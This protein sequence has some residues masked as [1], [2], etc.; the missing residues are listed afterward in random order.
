MANPAENI[1]YA[2]PGV[3]I[4]WRGLVLCIGRPEDFGDHENNLGYDIVADHSAATT[5]EVETII[6][7]ISRQ[8]GPEIEDL[9]RALERV[10]ASFPVSLPPHTIAETLIGYLHTGRLAG[11][12]IPPMMGAISSDSASEL[13]QMNDA[14]TKS[15]Q[16]ALLAPLDQITIEDLPDLEDRIVYALRRG[17]SDARFGDAVAQ[18]QEMLNP[19]VLAIIAAVL[20]LWVLSHATPIGY[21]IDAVMLAAGWIAIGWAIFGVIKKLFRAL[22]KILNA[23]T[24][25]ELDEA[26]EML[27]T[28]IETFGADMFLAAV[29]KG[30][31]KANLGEKGADAGK[32]LFDR[33]TTPK[34]PAP[35]ARANT[36]RPVRPRADI[37]DDII[38][39]TVSD[40]K[41]HPLRREYEDKVKG[42]SRYKARIRQDMT[43]AELESLAREASQARRDLGIYYKDA[44]PEALT[45]YIYDRNLNLYGDK[46][47]PTFDTAVESARK[48]LMRDL[49]LGEGQ[50]LD[51]DIYKHIIGG[52]ARP[53][54]DIN[55]VMAGFKQWLAA[56]P[57][58][59]FTKF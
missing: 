34:A 5:S 19:Q 48:R 32:A 1:C 59:Y 10:E 27:A 51:S 24:I 36:L 33:V 28:A 29:L 40:V 8:R 39:N 55:K 22:K 15:G 18:I 23:G 58:S 21:I 41:N 43:N 38:R 50:I 17:F 31:S 20:S 7:E 11:I 52:A 4:H 9:R 45:D 46:L 14:H 3:S 54:G 49:D 44:T 13:A 25:A 56:Q 42:L 53:N 35:K 6:M 47:G 26:G 57:D 16:S 2:S 12:V 37:E 30:A